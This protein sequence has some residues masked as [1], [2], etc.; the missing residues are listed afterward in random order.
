MLRK[1]DTRYKIIGGQHRASSRY[2]MIAH[3]VKNSHLPRNKNYKNIKLL[4]SKEDFVKWFMGRDFEGCSVD[5]VDV[6]G[7]YELSNMQ[8]I[9]NWVNNGKDRVKAKNGSCACY[10]CKAIKPLS[11]FAADK[12]RKFTGKSTICKKC[13][14]LRIK[15]ISKEDHDIRM[16]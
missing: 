13:D 7:H 5:R 16:H 1:V 10:S 8:V 9:P 3:R 6:N 11:E 12:R 2:Y 4:V 15:N 14:S